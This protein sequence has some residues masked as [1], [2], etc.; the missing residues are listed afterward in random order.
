MPRV[1][2]RARVINAFFGLL[3]S[4]RT[5]SL[6]AAFAQ[7]ALSGDAPAPASGA[8]IDPVLAD[9]KEQFRRAREVLSQ[10]AGAVPSVHAKKGGPPGKQPAK[11]PGGEGEGAA[12]PARKV[13]GK[14]QPQ[15]LNVLADVFPPIPVSS[16]GGGGGE[17]RGGEGRGSWGG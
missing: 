11:L 8:V 13:P 4:M 1:C 7:V 5:L 12:A 6:T 3:L 15:Q 2:V 14:L 17:G 9:R 10:S 16:G